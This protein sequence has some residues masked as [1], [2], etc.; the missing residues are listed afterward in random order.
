MDWMNGF[1]AEG[2]YVVLPNLTTAEQA[3][4]WPP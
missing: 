2:Q 1:T 4:M 3:C